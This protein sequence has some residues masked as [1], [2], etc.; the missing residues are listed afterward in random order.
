MPE[1]GDSVRLYFPN[2]N[3]AESYVNSSVNEQSSNSSSRSNP[4]E[5]S[6]KNKQ[7]KEVLFKPDRLVFTNNKG[8][9]IEIVDDE[10]I[11]IESDKSITIK[12]KEKYRNYQHGAGVEMSAPEKIAFQQGVPCWNLRMISMCRADV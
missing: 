2:E 6:I 11:L 4:D 8:M 5:K 7:G 3:E 9:S 12:A 1:K 10:G